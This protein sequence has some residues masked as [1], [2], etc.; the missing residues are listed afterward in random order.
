MPNFSSL[1]SVKDAH[2]AAYAFLATNDA[3]GQGQWRL[4]PRAGT[5]SGPKAG[6]PRASPAGA[7]GAEAAGRYACELPFDKLATPAVDPLEAVSN[8]GNR[9]KSIFK[10]WGMTANCK[11]CHAKL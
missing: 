4:R 5:T 8:D 2:G 9:T 3:L 11:S 1:P 7:W 6:A 10:T